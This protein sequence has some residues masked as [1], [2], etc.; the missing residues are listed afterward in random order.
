MIGI[1]TFH[2]QYNFGSALQAYALQTTLEK[3]GHSN[4]L[5]NFYYKKDMKIYDVRWDSKRPDVI[6]FDLLTAKK[7][8]AR[9]RAYHRFYP[10]PIQIHT[11]CSAR[12]RSTGRPSRPLPASP[13][14][15]LQLR[16]SMS[17]SLPG[18]SL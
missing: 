4:I 8:H 5:I 6:L 18:C 3:L 9:K 13:R 2:C 10:G 1:I 15:G 17:S 12:I 11:G 16:L 7:N 14:A